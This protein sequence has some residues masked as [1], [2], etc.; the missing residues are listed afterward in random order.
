MAN[1]AIL[2]GSE[3]R[4]GDTIKVWW[5]PGRDTITGLVPYRGP[6]EYLW[7]DDGGAML[8]EFAIMKTGMT[9][10]PLAHFEVIARA[11]A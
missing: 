10:E 3:L 4:V 8:A 9:I 6:L 7:R 1:E 11:S 2:H 5:Q